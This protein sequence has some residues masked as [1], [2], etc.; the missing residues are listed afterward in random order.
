M[1]P[2]QS[3][4]IGEILRDARRRRGV[5]LTDAATSTRVRESHL[6]ALEEEEFGGLGG[7]VYVIGFL[8]SYGRF[9]HVDDDALV[10]RY[11]ARGDFAPPPPREYDLPGGAWGDGDPRLDPATA[12]AATP[13]G[14]A[15]VAL[16]VI[17][18]VVL[19]ALLV[20]G[21]RADAAEVPPIA[22]TPVGIQP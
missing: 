17:G 15:R 7:D 4:G 11:Q 16:A 8:R 19:I 5:T 1:P 21:L 12:P 20:I 18:T 9:L 22:P 10:T 2:Q 6:A 13:R 3:T 14:P